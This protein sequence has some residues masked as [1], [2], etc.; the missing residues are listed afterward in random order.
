MKEYIRGYHIFLP[1]TWIK[2]CIYLLYP[3]LVSGGLYAICHKF[4]FFYFICIGFAGCAIVGVELMLDGQVFGGIA[5]KRN[6]CLEYLKT[7]IKGM[8]ILKKALITDAIRRFCSVAVI[9]FSLYP[10]VASQQDKHGGSIIIK[11]TACIFLIDFLVE[12]GVMV[13][14]FF[15][16][17]NLILASIY[18]IGMLAFMTAIWIQYP[19]PVWQ[20]LMAAAG[21]IAVTI[22]GRKQI[23]KRVRDSYYDNRMEKMRKAD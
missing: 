21:A 5:S 11:I 22:V 1:K 18:L 23:L 8:S 2:W 7:S 19:V 15:S 13:L 14:R 6:N 17:V 12:A 10:L 16:N 4:G 20:M 3:L 9:L